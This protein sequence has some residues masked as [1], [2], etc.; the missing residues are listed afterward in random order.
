MSK[1]TMKEGLQI[2]QQFAPHTKRINQDIRHGIPKAQHMSPEVAAG[3]VQK[4]SAGQLFDALSGFG[5]Q[6]VKTTDTVAKR[7][8]EIVKR[9]MDKREMNPDEY[10][11]FA[12]KSNLPYQWN[13][14]FM[15]L[16]DKALGEKFAR[17][18]Y[19]SAFEEVLN[20]DNVYELSEE[21]FREK[22]LEGVKKRAGEG[23]LNIESETQMLAFSN[24]LNPSLLKGTAEFTGRKSKILGDAAQQDRIAS[25]VAE[26]K[27]LNLLDGDTAKESLEFMRSTVVGQFGHVRGADVMNKIVDALA[28]DGQ[29]ALL[30]LV[31]D[32]EVGGKTMA[33]R[34]GGWDSTML[35]ASNKAQAMGRLEELQW[36]GDIGD[37]LRNPKKDREGFYTLLGKAPPSRRHE[38]ERIRLQFED[39]TARVDGEQ[40]NASNE[41]SKEQ[42]VQGLGQQYLEKTLRGEALLPIEPMDTGMKD[43]KGRPIMI[44]Q[45]DIQGAASAQTVPR[46][47]AVMGDPNLTVRE[48]AEYAANMAKEL[49]RLPNGDK[50][51]GNLFG[52]LHGVVQAV[53]GDSTQLDRVAKGHYPEDLEAALASMDKMLEIAP[54]ALPK[55]HK[56]IANGIF[57]VRKAT[58]LSPMESLQV[59]A[60]AK[61]LNIKADNKMMNKVMSK[62]G[63]S[64][65]SSSQLAPARAAV[66]T[67]MQAGMTPEEIMSNLERGETSQYQM[68]INLGS[69]AVGR[70]PNGTVTIAQGYESLFTEANDKFLRGKAMAALAN[71]Y[72][73]AD[74]KAVSFEYG[75]EGVQI[76]YAGLPVTNVGYADIQRNFDAA[77]KERQTTAKD[78]RNAKLMREESIS[79]AASL[80]EVGQHYL[81]DIKMP[82]L[83]S[84]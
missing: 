55:E 75:V 70:L 66:S 8:Q 54:D 83:P 7:T 28:Q 64:P 12:D 4:S 25:F 47:N 50:L 43:S 30:G 11:H 67:M 17:E 46:F 80:N 82:K 34:R 78:K 9:E 10:G 35:G 36:E 37:H 14:M 49:Q 38:I 72:V 58:G 33:E 77:V 2:A 16:Y 57:N 63:A 61:T 69:R 1:I 31:G 27:T 39:A 79:N 26:A 53:V 68:G 59:F 24:T 44:T 19:T 73:N 22:V 71:S 48:K 76:H 40:L 41:Q 3:R 52:H 42:I 65:L 60:K 62:L 18:N 29:T 84:K 5:T 15:K 45:E 56:I 51:L 21:E 13:P 20:S 81:N 23:G 6:L 74:P 32:L